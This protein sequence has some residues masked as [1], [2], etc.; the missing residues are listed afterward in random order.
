MV[1]GGS[2]VYTQYKAHPRIAAD[3][4]AALVLAAVGLVVVAA[5]ILR[6]TAAIYVRHLPTFALIGA[7]LVPIGLA[8][9]AVHLFLVR[10][11]PIRTLVAV[12]DE[13]PFVPLVVGL[14]LGNLQHLA[15][16]LLVGPAVVQAVSDIR[17]GRRP[18][19]LRAYRVAV[20][21]LGSV[22]GATLRA[23]AVVAL[24]ALTV[25]GLPW[26]IAR[27]V[28]WSF[29]GPAAI[30]DGDNAGEALAASA[31]AV[32]GHW[33]RAAAVGVVLF[34]VTAALGPL[35]GIPLMVG[36]DAPLNLVN[37]LSGLVYAFT[38]PF[39]A[40]G[41]TLLYQQLKGSR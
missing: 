27:S 4:L 11:E 39:A 10:N 15:A 35:L 22:A 25:V 23:L 1:R 7:V 29:I 26:A 38:H 36:L 17:A 3:V 31:A 40:I 16:L 12:T 8:A 21:R 37:G 34:V 6:A 5:Q 33:W 18:S 14:T 19:V 20:A 32:A 30:L 13:T 24:L 9:N 41:A 28:R 2:D